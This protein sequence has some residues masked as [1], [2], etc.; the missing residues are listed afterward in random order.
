MGLK[1]SRV[2]HLSVGAPRAGRCFP[3]ALGRLHPDLG[4]KM[5][6]AQSL[7]KLPADTSSAN[8]SPTGPCVGADQLLSRARRARLPAV[9]SRASGG[10]FARHDSTIFDSIK[11]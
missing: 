3:V 10:P 6:N 2:A 9:A 11:L 7:N 1:I 5:E 4:T 8:F